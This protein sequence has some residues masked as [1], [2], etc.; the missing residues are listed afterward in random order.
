MT[1]LKKRDG[2]ENERYT[3]FPIKNFPNYLEHPLVKNNY[4]SEIGYYSKALHH[5][6]ERL[7]G[8][9]EA[10]LFFCLEGKGTI[11]VFINHSWQSF[12]ILPGDIFC[13][14]PK[15]PHTYYSDTEK[16]WTILWLHF[17]SHLLNESFITV[18][19]KES[20]KDSQ[21]REMIESYLIDLFMMENKHFTLP[22]AIF[23]ASLLNHL[24]VTIYYFEDSSVTSRKNH[25]LT[26]CIQYMNQE[27]RNELTLA[28]LTKKFNISS[29]Y[30][31]AIFQE[32]TGKSP[33]EFF[34]KLK[35]DEACSLLRITNRKINEI[36][37][38]LGYKDAYYF[39]R[40]FKRN[41]G[42]SPKKYRER[43]DKV[44]KKFD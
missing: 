42:V 25:L 22:N 26:V 3:M 18:D 20:M 41:I 6:R 2:F 23:M 4:V 7:D 15:T 28:H 5:Y 11:T 16:P 8:V 36:A 43:F 1:E 10:I 33:I 29:S 40:I 24:L 27:L 14:P 38:S 32:E 21:K 19:K 37:N 30:L 13:I 31:N 9:D 34:I 39:S 44:P 12:D 35:M 17:S